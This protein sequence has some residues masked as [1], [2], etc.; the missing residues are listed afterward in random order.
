MHF[1]IELARP[2][3]AADFRA[4]RPIPVKRRGFIYVPQVDIKLSKVNA[5]SKQGR[6]PC[7]GQ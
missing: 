2:E 6:N 7:C 5:A 1:R 4:G 3:D